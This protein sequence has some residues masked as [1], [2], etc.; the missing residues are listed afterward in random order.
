MLSLLFWKQRR[1]S[2]G[3]HWS[4]DLAAQIQALLRRTHEPRVQVLPSQIP[5]AG[6]GVYAKQSLLPGHVACLY[7]GIFTPPLPPTTVDAE[8]TYLAGQ[9]TPSGVSPEHNAYVLNLRDVGG[10]LDGLADVSNESSDKSQPSRPPQHDNPSACG[11]LV[12][13][14]HSLKANVGVVSFFWKDVF[15]QLT[16][17]VIDEY[18]SIP[19]RMRSDRYPWYYD[20][21]DGKVV[22]GNDTSD[23]TVNVQRVCGAAMVVKKPTLIGDELYLDYGLL[24]PYPGWAKDWYFNEQ[25]Q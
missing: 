25:I 11:H 3:I 24:Q 4:Q 9:S 15:E 21:R 5:G 17:Q 19:N 20:P 1:H 2:G 16:V 18:Y 14:N 8:C 6:S 13:H 23:L 7:P 12:N 10:Y 22:Y